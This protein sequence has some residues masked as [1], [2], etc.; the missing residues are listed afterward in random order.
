MSLQALI[1]EKLTTELTPSHIEVINESGNHGARLGAES[2][3]KVIVVSTK[4]EGKPLLA[5]HRM[6]NAALKE[7]LVEDI[8]A[9]SMTTRTPAQWAA[10]GGDKVEP[11]PPCAGGSTSR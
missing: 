5:R 1:E 9:L 2:H 11:T 4:F 8:H 10:E 6:V 3:F 7:E